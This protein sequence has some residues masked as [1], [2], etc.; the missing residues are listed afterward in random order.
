MTPTDLE[1]H[2]T[3]CPS[4]FGSSQPTRNNDERRVANCP[5]ELIERIVAVV[6][7]VLLDT[8]VSV[9]TILFAV[10]CAVCKCVLYVISADGNG[11]VTVVVS[12]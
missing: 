11:N 3:T 12:T 2:P 7:V 8:E 1:K 5:P 10:L 9:L 6:V 4:D